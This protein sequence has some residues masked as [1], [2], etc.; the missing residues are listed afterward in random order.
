MLAAILVNDNEG[1][2]QQ[3]HQKARSHAS[4]GVCWGQQ[5]QLEYQGKQQGHRWG[6]YVSKKVQQ[7]LHT[8]SAI[9]SNPPTQV[10]NQVTLQTRA[11]IKMQLASQSPR[12]KLTVEK[13]AG[14]CADIEMCNEM[15]CRCSLISSCSKEPIR[16]SYANDVLA[17]LY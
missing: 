1:H 10:P 12:K 17:P 4:A 8:S 2:L 16:R 6:H 11:Y 3:Q 15:A 14:C 9:H 5:H 13:L 7:T